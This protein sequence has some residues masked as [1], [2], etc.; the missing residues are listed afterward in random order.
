MEAYFEA[1]QGVRGRLLGIMALALKLQKD[2]FHLPG[3][4]DH[5]MSVM[6]AVCYSLEASDPDKGIFGCGAH[7]DFGMCTLL[8]TA[9]AGLQVGA[10]GCDTFLYRLASGTYPG[11]WYFFL[12]AFDHSQ[13]VFCTCHPSYAP[14]V[15]ICCS[16]RGSAQVW[17]DVK[18]MDGAFIVNIGDML[19]RW[20][21]GKWQS[22][23]HRVI[24][25]PGGSQQR[26]SIPFFVGPNFDCVVECL[27]TCVSP[28]EPAK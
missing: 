4:F 21:N 13:A 15:Q 1:C 20:T 3:M 10:T 9:G 11:L 8:A 23:L 14:L 2:Y 22:T 18:R 24:I 6:N 7:T 19:H 16:R 5:G 25:P 12:L 17:Q 26:Y 27:P 28:R